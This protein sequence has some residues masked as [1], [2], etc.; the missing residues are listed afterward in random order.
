[1]TDEQT[2]GTKSRPG[3]NQT[4]DWW[5]PF[6]ANFRPV[7]DRLPAKSTNALVR[8]IVR[9]LGLRRGMTVLDCPCG[10]GRVGLPLAR[11]GT[12]VTG[13]DI[14]PHFIEEFAV[15]AKRK[16]LT[17]R[18]LEADMRRIDFRTEFDVALNLWTSFGYFTNE[19][20]N[21]KVLR[22]LYHA[23]R[24][25]G[26]LLLHVISRDWIVA[27]FN[28]RDWWEDGRDHVLVRRRFDFATSISY[29][30]WIYVKDGKERPCRCQLRA[31]SYHELLAMFRKVGFVDVEGYGSMRDEP[32]GRDSRMMYVFGTKPKMLGSRH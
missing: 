5:I 14:S 16:G 31:Y 23:L 26:R 2:C 20:E 29:D 12:K 24:P 21:L 17:V 3:E 8:Y 15:K 27:N 10:I 9:K 1:M 19:A 28:D 11:L 13:V 32:I 18:L 6:Y 22:G 30:D 7:F 25:G 4:K